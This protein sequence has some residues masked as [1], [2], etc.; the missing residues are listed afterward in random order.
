MNEPSLAAAKARAIRRVQA[1]H[2]DEFLREMRVLGWEYTPD[3]TG[4]PGTTM[5]QWHKVEEQERVNA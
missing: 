3:F 1:N 2:W 4:P 5:K